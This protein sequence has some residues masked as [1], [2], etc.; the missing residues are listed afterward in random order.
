M[1]KVILSTILA[2]AFLVTNAQDAARADNIAKLK[3]ANK[4]FFDSLELDKQKRKQIS[5]INKN[6]EVAAKS[7]RG[8]ERN[9]ET[10]KALRSLAEERDLEIEQVLTADQYKLYEDHVKALRKEGR[11]R[12]RKPD[13]N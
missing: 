3:K 12:L 10:A 11:A 9:L 8:E 1:K 4:E 13:P 5:E 6:F 2:V 7:L